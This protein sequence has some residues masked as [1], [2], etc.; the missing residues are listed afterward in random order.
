MS[1]CGGP[2]HANESR[3]T[4]EPRAAA[5]HVPPRNTRLFRSAVAAR[6]SSAV[7]GPTTTTLAVRSAVGP[8]HD[9]A[10]RRKEVPRLGRIVCVPDPGSSTPSGSSRMRSAPVTFQTTVT[11]SPGHTKGGVILNV[12]MAGG[13]SKTSTSTV[14]P[15]VRRN[16]QITP[17]RRPDRKFEAEATSRGAPG[18]TGRPQIVTSDRENSN[19]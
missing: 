12:R 3:E 1:Q 8:Y 18:H 5:A 11:S 9:V 4:L 17:R 6:K 16:S 19:F 7:F 13:A 15:R 10:Q 2:A 14:E